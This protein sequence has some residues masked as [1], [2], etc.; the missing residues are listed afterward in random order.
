VD[1]ELIKQAPVKLIADP[2]HGSGGRWLEHLLGGG[3][4]QVTTIRA[5]RDV[6]FGGVNPEPLAHCLAPLATAIR[7]HQALLGL[8]TD[9]DADRVGAMDEHGQF[10]NSHQIVAIILQHLAAQRGLRGGVVRTFS[11][12]VLIRR[13]AEHYQLPLYETPIGFKYITELMLSEDILIGGEESGGIG[14]KG[15]IPERDGILNSLLLAE[16]VI[17]SGKTPSQ[18]LQAIW[19]QF[20][21]FYYDR[22]DLA[23]PIAVAQAFVAQT[24]A[25]P[26]PTIAGEKVTALATLDGT[27]LIFADESWL[28][29]RSSGTEPVLRLYAEAT[30][31]QQVLALL[32]DAETRA[33]EFLTT[34]KSSD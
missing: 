14:I 8:A 5:E 13:I 12:S 30:S 27:K 4:C 23:V 21:R 1:L 32:A 10:I 31:A 24:Q 2:M 29:L 15:H 6:Y 26:P 7:E 9:G 20:G 33:R 11:Q 28:L 16:A 25:Q 19:Q 17:A 22:R 3:R 34:F 18:L